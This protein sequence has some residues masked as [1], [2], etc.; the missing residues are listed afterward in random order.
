MARSRSITD[1]MNAGLNPSQIT[2]ALQSLAQNKLSQLQA[3]NPLFEM[4]QSAPQQTLQSL[5]GGASPITPE[6]QNILQQ[7][8]QF[9]PQAIQQAPIDNPDKQIKENKAVKLTPAERKT[10]KVEELAQ[11]KQDIVLAREQAKNDIIEQRELRKQKKPYI[12]KLNA[13]K[14]VGDETA[15]KLE[16]MEQ[17]VDREGGLPVAAFYKL[18][19]NLEGINPAYA[20]GALGAAGTYLGGPIGGAIGGTIGGLISPVAT[21]LRYGQ[22]LTSPN[23]EEFEKLSASFINQ[24]KAIFGARITDRDLQEFLKTVPNLEQTDNGKKAIIKNIRIFNKANEAKYNAYK[25]ILRENSGKIP[26]DLEI[27]V[28][29]RARP[30]LDKLSKQFKI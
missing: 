9:Q 11:K 22:R 26:F 19:T 30:E 18:F 4:Q 10:L 8:Q 28:E 17:L 5:L 15:L 1:E 23:T 21:M 3:R 2:S 20:A 14:E 12:D 25:D 16:R 6:S 7:I 29:E 24:A 13:Y 27:Q